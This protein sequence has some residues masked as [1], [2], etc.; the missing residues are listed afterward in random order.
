LTPYI[1][2]MVEA[3]VLK[4]E[5]VA[6]YRRNLT[7]SFGM[8]SDMFA[9]KLDAMKASKEYKAA[10]KAGKILADGSIPDL[11]KPVPTGV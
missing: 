8:F 1:D 2:A 7:T 6:V 5:H 10:V 3:D 11:S 9:T 4:S